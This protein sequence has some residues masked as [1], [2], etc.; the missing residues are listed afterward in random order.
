MEQGCWSVAP[1]GITWWMVPWM[2]VHSIIF[3]TP[4]VVAV[5][6]WGAGGG[7]AFP[8]DPLFRVREEE[9]I[10]RASQRLMM[11]VFELE[12]ELMA[13]VNRPKKTNARIIDDTS[14]NSS[15]S[16]DST[17]PESCSPQTTATT[18]P[19]DDTDNSIAP[20]GVT[21]VSSIALTVPFTCDNN[22]VLPVKGSTT[23]RRGRTNTRRVG[24]NSKDSC[25]PEGATS[26]HVVVE[27]ARLR[28]KASIVSTVSE[29]HEKV[30]NHNI[31]NLPWRDDPCNGELRGQ[32][33]GPINDAL[34]PHGH[35]ILIL[36]GNDFLKFHGRWVNGELIAFPGTNQRLLNEDEKIEYD[37]CALSAR[38]FS[39]DNSENDTLNLPEPHVASEI[40]GALTE[41]GSELSRTTCS[42]HDY[43]A[44][45]H[46]TSEITTTS[47]DCKYPPK[48]EYR[49][50]EVARTP[51]H[52]IIHRSNKRAV[53]S[54]STLQKLDQAFIKRSNGLW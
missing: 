41:S 40:D 25:A 51:R 26:A 30:S 35:G 3:S 48:Q 11:V 37:R 43:H 19:S 24:V 47:K 49:L 52:M 33:S 6:F 42:I 8:Q 7:Y 2:V 23:T 16:C 45:M 27:F 17:A 9:A 50:G 15:T 34:Q 29:E 13:W 12:D 44:P 21:A 32:Y 36:G 28:R 4:G 10:L 31:S 22:D 14:N 38:I 54:L 39:D 20:P 53:Q 1:S 5:V 46:T 18:R